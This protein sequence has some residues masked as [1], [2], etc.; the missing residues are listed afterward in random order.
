MLKLRLTRVHTYFHFVNV[1]NIVTVRAPNPG[2]IAWTPLSMV[3]HDRQHVLHLG[4][5]L[6]VQS[7]QGQ[8]LCRFGYFAVRP[9][10][11]KRCKCRG[12]E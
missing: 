9:R 1:M 10:F 11:G 2:F 6:G 4:I 8:I 7:D 5:F 12:R 3:M